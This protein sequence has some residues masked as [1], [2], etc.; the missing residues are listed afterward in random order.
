MITKPKLFL[1]VCMLAAL[2]VFAEAQTAGAAS[3]SPFQSSIR[4]EQG[5]LEITWQGRRLLLYAFQTNQFKPYVREF[6]TLKGDNVLVDSP[7]DHLHHHG[8][9]YAIRVN[10]VNFW[11]ERDHRAMNDIRSR[12]PSWN[13]RERRL[14]STPLPT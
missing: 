9:M 12:R 5:T 14:G 2:S 3:A 13:K 8:L 10:G 6:Y 4:P 11:E 7:P 1:I